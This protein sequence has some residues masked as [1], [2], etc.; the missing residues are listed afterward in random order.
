MVEAQLQGA[1][2]AANATNSASSDDTDV[3]DWLAVA[4]ANCKA[5]GNAALSAAADAAKQEADAAAAVECE[6]TAARAFAI[7]SRL[8]GLR[9]GSGSAAGQFQADAAAHAA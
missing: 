9:P 6:A 1:R 7:R 5:L 8:V 2:T 4:G 3:S